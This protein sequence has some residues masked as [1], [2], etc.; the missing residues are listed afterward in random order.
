MAGYATVSALLPQLMAAF[1]LSSAQGGWLAGM[2]FAGYMLGVLPLVGLTDRLAS[3][4][5]YLWCSTLSA[6]S[7]FGVALSNDWRLALL[8]RAVAGVALAGMYMPGLRALTDG[9]EGPARARIAAVYTSAFTVGASLSF[10]TGRIGIQSGWRGAFVLAG[11]LG[12]AGAALAWAALPRTV[13]PRL[14][15]PV[16]A[17]ARLLPDPRPVFGNR[18]ALVLV[19]LYAATIWGS[20]GVRQWI[21][22]FLVFCAAGQGAGVTPE[23]SMLAAGAVI[24]LLGVPAGLLGNELAL[25]FGLRRTAMAVFGLS[26]LVCVLFGAVARLHYPV[27]IVASLLGGFIVQGNFANLTSGVLIVAEVEHR[28]A[29][30][31]LY[32]C[33]GFGGGFLGTLLFGVALG[34]FG[35]VTQQVAWMMAFASCGVACLAGGIATWLLSP[36]VGR[37]RV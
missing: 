22:V 4:N 20:A 21:V 6:L 11:V 35:G 9:L 33:G 17:R 7:C 26:T 18:D 32:S 28:G 5:I 37:T 3:R 10:L 27:A 24:N 30:V 12:V 2:M 14:A 19:W 1:S 8:F 25:R 16:G 36:D 31:A 15:P 29:T 34:A 23:W 13:L